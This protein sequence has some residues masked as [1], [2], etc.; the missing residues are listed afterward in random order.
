M[1]AMTNLE[2]S[3]IPITLDKNYKPRQMQMSQEEASEITNTDPAV[4]Q[5]DTN[6]ISTSSTSVQPAL[7]DIYNQTF[8]SNAPSRIQSC[9]ENWTYLRENYIHF[10]AE[11]CEFTTPIWRLLIDIKAIVPTD[12]NN[13]V[14]K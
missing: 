14:P 12:L 6:R 11:D 2:T 5:A 8:D 4:V 10:L 9:R 7:P 1:Q 3:K 13:N